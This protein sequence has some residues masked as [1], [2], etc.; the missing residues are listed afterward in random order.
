MI[1]IFNKKLHADNRFPYENTLRFSPKIASLSVASYQDQHIQCISY[2]DIANFPLLLAR[3]GTVVWEQLETVAD[4]AC[5]TGCIGAWL[6][7]HGIRFIDGVDLTLHAVMV[8]EAAQ[9]HVG[10]LTSCTGV[11]S[12]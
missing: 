9:A 10:D 3:I 7:E 2:S 11:L 8:E 12:T 4:L 6:K 1:I 5:G